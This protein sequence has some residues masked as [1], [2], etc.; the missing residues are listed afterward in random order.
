MF[1]QAGEIGVFAEEA[2]KTAARVPVLVLQIGGQLPVGGGV[3]E[4]PFEGEAGVEPEELALLVREIRK[5]EEYLGSPVKVPTLSEQ[6]TRKSLQKCL[7]AGRDIKAGEVFSDGNLTAKRTGGKGISALYY[8][9]IVGT[10][11]TRDY[12]A[13]DIIR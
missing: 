13:D 7:V 9:R 5:V 6:F 8:Q 2:G 4:E 11:A 10:K 3:G 12:K 1:A